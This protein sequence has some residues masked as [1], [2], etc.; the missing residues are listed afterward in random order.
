MHFIFVLHDVR[1]F[2]IP[3]T[4]IK[5]SR[6]LLCKILYDIYAVLNFFQR[7]RSRGRFYNGVPQRGLRPMLRLRGNQ[8]HRQ[9]PNG[10]HNT[11]GVGDLIFPKLSSTVMALKKVDFGRFERVVDNLIV[12]NKTDVDTQQ[13]LEKLRTDVGERIRR[14]EQKESIVSTS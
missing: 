5:I 3:K 11:R 7:V 14:E 12:K 2:A 8:I 13:H 4:K 9:R 6:L 1:T 10:S